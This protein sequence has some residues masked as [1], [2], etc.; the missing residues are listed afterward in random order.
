MSATSTSGTCPAPIG[1]GVAERLA[2]QYVV[3]DQ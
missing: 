3:V 2:H 1:E